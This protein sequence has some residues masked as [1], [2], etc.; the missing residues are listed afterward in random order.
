MKLTAPKVL[1]LAAALAALASA[2]ESLGAMDYNV[3]QDQLK[4]QESHLE[5]ANSRLSAAKKDYAVSQ[6]EDAVMTDTRNHFAQIRSY[7]DSGASVASILLKVGSTA[8][9]TMVALKEAISSIENCPTE[10]KALLGDL[11]SLKRAHDKVLD[12]WKSYQEGTNSPEREQAVLELEALKEQETNLKEQLDKVTNELEEVQTDLQDE[13]NFRKWLVEDMDQ[14]RIFLHDQ[15]KHNALIQAIDNN[16]RLNEEQQK[17][18]SALLSCF[19][20][21]TTKIAQICHLIK[22]APLG[23]HA[24]LVKKK[25]RSET[26]NASI[27]AALYHRW[28]RENEDQILKYGKT[29]ATLETDLAKLK[30]QVAEAEQERKLK[31]QHKLEPKV[32]L[33]AWQNALEAVKDEEECFAALNTKHDL[34]AVKSLIYATATL[35]SAFKRF[36]GEMKVYMAFVS[37]AEKDG[38]GMPTAE[39]KA[40]LNQVEATTTPA[41]RALEDI[42]RGI[43][44][45]K[46]AVTA[47]QAE[48]QKLEE[49]ACRRSAST[50]AVASLAGM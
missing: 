7:I 31:E 22:T 4:T 40:H 38:A 10:V 15:E 45:V 1:L 18:V 19:D 20:P 47:A 25:I 50:A 3:L 11:D 42:K 35:Y 37:A 30:T 16:Q 17:V 9:E 32:L 33:A 44:E 24:N 41:P 48:I 43:E 29:I 34:P 13:Q 28:F 46:R 2:T 39:L 6:L 5:A 14:A 8:S 26:G 27:K 12:N 21:D 49:E 36:E 23:A